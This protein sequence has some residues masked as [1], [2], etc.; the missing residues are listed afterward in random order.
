MAVSSEKDADNWQI[1]I[2]VA[3]SLTIQ[4]HSTVSHLSQES[5]TF[6]QAAPRLRSGV[7]MHY[8]QMESAVRCRHSCGAELVMCETAG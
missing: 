3:R 5:A 1:E 2:G 8:S 4:L 6:P 7:V